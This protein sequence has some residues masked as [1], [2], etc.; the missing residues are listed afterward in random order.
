MA[1]YYFIPQRLAKTWPGL[2][3]LGWRLEAFGIRLLIGMMRRRSLEDASRFAYSLFRRIG[4]RTAMRRHVLRNLYVAL[5]ERS[6][7]EIE[8]VMRDI[9]GNLG[10]A[11]A[12]IVHLEDIWQAREE[13]LEFVVHPDVRFLT[14]PRR[15]AVLVTAHVGPWT[16]GNFIARQFD[17]PLS[18]VYAEESNPHTH[19]IMRELRGDLQVN[20]LPR[21]NSMRHLM[22]ELGEGRC[23][24]LGSDV[25]L[26]SGE[27]V[28]FFGHDM[29]SNTVPARLALRYDCELI[30]VR[31]ER[32]PN[33][34]FRITIGA[35][36]EP[37]ES[38]TNDAERAV[39]MTRKLNAI[40]ENWIR[41][42]P[43]QWM[44]L[45]RRWP[46]P[47]LNAAADARAAGGSR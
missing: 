30:A 25:R 4:P 13:R 8:E 15:P 29:A 46:K 43:S 24:G 17:F 44:C 38:A 37:P 1:K 18:I 19:D 22:R 34:R 23:V 28:P 12:E 21:D 20:L 31:T 26:D 41:E 5:A 47:V 2:R 27:M 10:V 11:F 42:A 33:G 3:P 45:A 7:E 9:F 39:A 40:F 14:E 36:V 35:P 32:L 16:L 6:N